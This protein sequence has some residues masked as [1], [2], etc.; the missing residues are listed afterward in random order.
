MSFNTITDYY[1]YVCHIVAVKKLQSEVH[2]IRLKKEKT[3]RYRGAVRADQIVF[4]DGAKLRFN[5]EIEI[6]S[7]GVLRKKYSYHY[8]SNGFF[9]RYDKD[10]AK[11]IQF[12]HAECHLHANAETPRYITH[13]TNLEEIIEFIFANFYP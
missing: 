9:F 10:P 6:A 4:S 3:S 7:D 11:V 8:E 2:K 13:E 1:Q 12:R 5:E